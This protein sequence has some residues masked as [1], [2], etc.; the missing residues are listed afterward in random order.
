MNET[1]ITNFILEKYLPAAS[2]QNFRSIANVVDGLKTEWTK[3]S[4]HLI[5]IA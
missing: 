1:K 3:N 5:W 4:L 2:Y